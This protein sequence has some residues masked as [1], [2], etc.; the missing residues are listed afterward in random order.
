MECTFG[1]LKVMYCSTGVMYMIGYVSGCM[2]EFVSW[3]PHVVT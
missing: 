1:C 2:W 3:S